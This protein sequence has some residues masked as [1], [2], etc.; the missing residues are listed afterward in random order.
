M[1]APAFR[2]SDR[3]RKRQLTRPGRHR[4]RWDEQSPGIPFGHRS[5]LDPQSVLKLRVLDTDPVTG[6]PQFA[7]TAMAGVGY[8]LLY[9]DSLTPPVWR[10][11]V[12]VPVDV[13]ARVFLV[14][15]IPHRQACRCVSIAL[16]PRFNPSGD[17]D[18]DGDGIPDSW[19]LQIF[20]HATGLA[21]DLSR[22]Q[23]DADGDGMTNLQEYL[24]GT[25]P[26]I[27]RAASNCNFRV[28]MPPLAVRNSPSMPCPALLTRF[29]TQIASL[30]AFGRNSAT[31]R[32][33]IPSGPS[34][35]PI[36][37]Q[38]IPP[39]VSTAS[40]LHSNPDQIASAVLPPR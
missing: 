17:P 19:M 31:S 35:S 28:S 14:E 11:L 5:F 29:N 23:D 36:R 8:T 13:T 24:A 18:S 33:P 21:S 39:L 40:S 12:D 30:R 4:Q 38:R 32:L 9:S 34:H 1:D 20:G 7:F 16:S 26:L 15:M 10:K 27:R 25:D 3:P 2:P 22:A 37:V 6:R